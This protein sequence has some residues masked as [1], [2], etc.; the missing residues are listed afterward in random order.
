MLDFAQLGNFV[1][2][3]TSDDA[4]TRDLT[5]VEGLSGIPGVREVLT[6]RTTEDGSVEDE[7]TTL[8]PRVVTLDGVL[9]AGPELR[10]A[11]ADWEAFVQL[12]EQATRP[13]GVEFTWRPLGGDVTKTG[14]V[15]LAGDVDTPLEGYRRELAYT[16]SLRA[17]SPRW[18]D[19]EAQTVTIGAPTAGGGFTFPLVFPLRF[20]AGL[21][22]GRVDVSNGGNTLTWPQFVIGGPINSPVI[23]NATTGRGLYFEGLA[24]AAGDTLVVTTDPDNRLALVSGTDVSSALRMGDSYFFALE[25]GA[26]TLQFYG[27]G[28]YGAGTSLTVSWQNAYTT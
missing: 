27:A 25:P 21:V 14:L 9:W 5:H 24:V 13:P 28:G 16:V 8:P 7:D 26:Q 2:C 22:G 19:V 12:C 23:Y 6:D 1:L 11:Y 4:G 10:D 15:R 18:L 20:G 17:S 3:D